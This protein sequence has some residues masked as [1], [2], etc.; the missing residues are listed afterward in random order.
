MVHVKIEDYIGGLNDDDEADI[1]GF[2]VPVAALKGL[3]ARGYVH[4]KT[5]S[6]NRTITFWGKT[7]TACFTEKNLREMR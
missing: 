7:C 1:E 5:Y 4:L 2:R 6:E 3:V